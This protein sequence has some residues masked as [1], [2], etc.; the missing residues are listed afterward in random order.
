MA[1][2]EFKLPD[3]GEGVSEG[4]IV[5]WHIEPGQTIVEDEPM[6]EVMTDKA[7]VTIASPRSGRVA[8]TFGKVG[9]TVKVHSVLVVF[10]LDE[11][12][13]AGA[14]SKPSPSPAPVTKGEPER[15]AEKANAHRK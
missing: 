10:E 12:G 6:V 4:E 11:S 9:E 5:A 15:H 7:T 13:R 1:R 3:I 14:P 2:F 8:E